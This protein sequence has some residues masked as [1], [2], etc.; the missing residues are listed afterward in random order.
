MNEL[1]AFLAK[2]A[3]LTNALATVASAI[4]ALAAFIISVVSLFVARAT[5]KNQHSHNVLSVKPIPMVSVADYEDRLTVKILNNGSG[6]L[7]IKNVNVKKQSQA[8]E[9]LIAWMPSLPDG[10]YWATFVGPIENHSLLPGNEIKLLELTGDHSDSTFEKFRDESRAA[11][12]LLTVVVE[13]TD[14]YGSAF[15]EQEKSLSW[16]G[17]NISES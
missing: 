13:Y 5:L 10:I 4:I 15:P 3:N 8:R 16:F 7:I 2:E 1:L 17:R 14:V 6:P 11:L 9:S 12:C